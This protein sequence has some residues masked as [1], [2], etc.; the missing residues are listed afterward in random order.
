M[1]QEIIYVSLY[2]VLIYFYDVFWNLIRFTDI[3][4]SKYE[5]SLKVG[6]ANSISTPIQPKPEPPNSNVIFSCTFNTDG[7]LLFVVIS[8]ILVVYNADN[9]EVVTKP[10][11]AGKTISIQLK[12]LSM[13]LPLPKT[14]RLSPLLRT[15]I[16][17]QK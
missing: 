6:L 10:T 8:D 5:Q 16:S 1:I 15:S 12:N 3:F 4:N 13:L 2:G 11:R 17:I 9:G 7:T 14:G